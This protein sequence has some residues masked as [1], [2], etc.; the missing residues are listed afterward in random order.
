MQLYSAAF[1]QEDLLPLVRELLSGAVQVLSLVAELQR[2]VVG[3]AVFT[4][5]GI[6]GRDEKVALLGPLAVDPALHNSGLGSALVREGLQQ[7]EAGGTAR[8]LVLGDPG[9]YARFGFKPDGEIATPY[10][11][12]REWRDAWQAIALGSQPGLPRGC[13][14]V[15]PVWQHAELWLP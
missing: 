6:R 3:H 10:E 1:P 11:L 12:P 2:K 7:L 14:A 9:Y 4:H 15:P 13:L 8:V 5:C